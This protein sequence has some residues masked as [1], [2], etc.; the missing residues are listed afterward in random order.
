MSFS[1]DDFGNLPSTTYTYSSN[2]I[3]GSGAPMNFRKN[4]IANLVPFDLYKLAKFV[5]NLL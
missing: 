4:S 3:I 5:I 1:N 2:L